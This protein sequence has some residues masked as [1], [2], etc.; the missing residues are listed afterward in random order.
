VCKSEKLG[1]KFRLFPDSD[2]FS[3]DILSV[4]SSSAPVVHSPGVSNPVH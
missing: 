4:P 2:P 1:G 3:G